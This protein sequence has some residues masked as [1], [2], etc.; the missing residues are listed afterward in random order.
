MSEFDVSKY[1]KVFDDGCKY[2]ME[3]MVD[4]LYEDIVNQNK[5][6]HQL[7]QENEE[8]KTQ[9]MQ[10][11]EVNIFFNTLDWNDDPC[12]IC[13]QKHC[14]DEIEDICKKSWHD[15]GI[16]IDYFKRNNYSWKQHQI[17]SLISRFEQILQK[18][19]EVKE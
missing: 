6:L 3:D 16:T 2:F 15:S 19:K 11:D 7:K 13:P 1:F 10:K 9:L 18:I 12:E 17:R 8:L 5:Q 14:L 4:E